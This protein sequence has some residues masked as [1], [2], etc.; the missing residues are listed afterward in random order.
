M[1]YVTT[2]SATIAVDA[3][4]GN[5]IWKSK[6][7]YPPET[8]RIVCC[9][10]INRG[11]AI[12]DGKLFRTTLDANVVAIDAKTGKELWRQNAADIKLGYSMTMAP[13]YADGVVI[14]GVSGAEFGTRDFIDGWDP[15]TGKHLWRTYTIP[16]PGEPGS[17]TWKGDTWK[18]GGGSTWITGSFDPEMHTVFWGIGNPGP[19]N[20]ATRPGDNLYT[21]SVLALDPK[22]GSIKWHYQFSPNNPFDYDAVAEMV[23]ADIKVDG[24][25]DQS[26]PR[27]QSQRLLLCAR[28]HDGQADRG[29]SLCPGELGLEHRSEDRPTGRDRSRRQ[30]AQGREGRSMALD[31]RRQELGADVLRPRHGPS[32]RQ[33]AQLRQTLQDDLAGL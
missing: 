20:A 8:V 15:E 14:T 6:I 9:G 11:A 29:Q 33:H 27:R 26:D 10:V 31:P 23:L 16:A 2:N 22:T 17:E 25:D 1:L 7:E 12:A 30:G 4:T 13:L 5:Q 19:F 3:K 18:F 24:K 32:L 28:S 21:C